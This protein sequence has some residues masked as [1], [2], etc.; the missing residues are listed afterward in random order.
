MK[1]RILL[2]NDDSSGINKLSSSS[3]PLD[4]I[5]LIHNVFLDYHFDKML[6]HDS[7]HVSMFFYNFNNQVYGK[8][9]FWDTIITNVCEA[10]L[11]R[12]WNANDVNQ[13]KA[14]AYNL[15][16]DAGMFTTI[17]GVEIVK[18]FR[19][20]MY[21]IYD[22]AISNGYLSQNE[23]NIL[24]DI[25]D[26]IYNENYLAVDSMVQALDLSN[27]NINSEPAVFVFKS[28]YKHSKTYWDNLYMTSGVIKSG[29]NS[30]GTNGLYEFAINSIDA[31]AGIAVSFTGIGAFA[32]TIFGGAVSGFADA[33]IG[34]IGDA[35]TEDPCR[36]PVCKYY[37]ITE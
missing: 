37:G 17:N 32:S 16:S 29:D 6:P 35:L 20:N 33:A 27:Y 14:I 21:D 30:L 8:K 25:I 7:N 26:A 28:I 36:C 1:N 2:L 10:A 19:S 18:D 23:Y 9:I 31:A 4:S 11:D 24:S 34:I 22:A 3:N 5:G 15:Y 12:G 13:A